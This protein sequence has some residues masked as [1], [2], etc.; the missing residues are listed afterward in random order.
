[1]IQLVT[2]E[3]LLI[4]LF[5]AY[6]PSLEIKKLDISGNPESRAQRIFEAM[7]R[8]VVVNPAE[9][10]SIFKVLNTIAVI[11]ND[12]A[13]H[14]VIVDYLSV[15]IA[16]KRVYDSLH[17]AATFSKRRPIAAMAAFIAVQ[18][19]SENAIIRDGARTLWDAFIMECS[20]VAQGN[21]LRKNITAPTKGPVERARGLKEFQSELE[22]YVRLQSQQRD[23]IAFVVPNQTTNG[24][25]RYYVNTSPPERD[26]LQVKKGKSGMG[27]D[28]NMT[29]FE[30]R[31]YYVTNRIWISETKTGDQNYILNLFL[32]T[33]LGSSIDR[34][35]RVHCEHRFPVFRTK[36]RFL[37]EITLPEDLSQNNEKVYVSQLKIVVAERHA[38]LVLE[39]DGEGVYMP[40]TYEGT[41]YFSIHDQINKVQQRRFP[42]E[43][44]TIAYAEI[45][46]LLHPYI[47]D[48]DNETP[49]GR[50]SEFT[51]VTFPIKPGGCT[52][53]YETKYS[54]DRKLR[55]DAMRLRARWKLDGVSDEVFYLKMSD[56]ER[57]GGV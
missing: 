52:P 32:K 51:K 48:K 13:N 6:A 8:L 39:G 45:V 30:I 22:E 24:Y 18:C 38:D 26:V 27:K 28:I 56:A 42:S 12:P 1:M 34:R 7:E 40:V 35:H 17:Y 10:S 29:G 23:Y 15:H 50:S 2:S 37:R 21:Y 4:E 57:N 55:E 5:E 44:W 3:E 20:K 33:V 53:K 25:T 16:L 46:A 11:N 9:H 19:K 41:E 36:E 43:L 14:K 49:I 54:L 47:Y 31:H